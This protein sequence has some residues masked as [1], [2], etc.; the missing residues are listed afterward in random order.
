VRMIQVTAKASAFI[1]E[2]GGHLT[3]YLKTL[4]G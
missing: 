2:R 4:S 3:L 1:A